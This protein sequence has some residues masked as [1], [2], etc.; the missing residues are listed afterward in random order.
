[1][2]ETTEAPAAIKPCVYVLCFAKTPYK[3][4]KHYLGYTTLVIADRIKR[5]RSKYGAR[6]IK[7]LLAA[8]GDFVLADTWDCENEDEARKLE[9]ALKRQG[10]GA[11]CCSLCNPGNGRGAGRGRNRYGITPREAKPPEAGILVAGAHT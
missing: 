10:G 8:G 1:M 2:S 11:R 4:A 5:H 6:L 9:K 7:V 3:G